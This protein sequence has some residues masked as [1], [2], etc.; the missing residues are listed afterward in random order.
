MDKYRETSTDDYEPYLEL[1]KLKPPL[2]KLW[3]CLLRELDSLE[4]QGW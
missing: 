1:I 2:C 3:E 4:N